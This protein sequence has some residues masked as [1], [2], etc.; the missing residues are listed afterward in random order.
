MLTES[1]C[2]MAPKR[3]AALVEPPAATGVQPS[4]QRGVRSGS[5]ASG[6]S[7]VRSVVASA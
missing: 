1:Y 2:V 6:L 5:V 3:L 7:F 4:Q